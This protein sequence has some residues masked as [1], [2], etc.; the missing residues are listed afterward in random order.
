MSVLDTATS[1]L[2]ECKSITEREVNSK[3]RTIKFELF[4]IVPADVYVDEG[5][6]DEGYG[7]VPIDSISREA[8]RDVIA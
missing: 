2:P 3:I 8:N 6:V 4:L 7:S 1:F 5:G